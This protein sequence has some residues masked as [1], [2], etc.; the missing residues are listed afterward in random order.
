MIV[1]KV[2]KNARILFVGINPH[3]GSYRRGV[4][5]SVLLELPGRFSLDGLRGAERRQS[6]WNR[7]RDG[8]GLD[9]A[10]H[11]GQE[12][13]APLRAGSRSVPLR[14]SGCIWGCADLADTGTKKT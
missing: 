14:S 6:F 3:L 8:P 12:V 1:Y 7:I 4:P 5:F 10:E 2:S 9:R 13:D 11:P